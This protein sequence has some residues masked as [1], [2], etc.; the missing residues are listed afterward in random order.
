MTLIFLIIAINC[1]VSLQAIRLQ[2]YRS[3]MCIIIIY[4]SSHILN[5]TH[6]HRRW[7]FNISHATLIGFGAELAHKKNCIVKSFNS[8]RYQSLS[9]S[10]SS[11]FSFFSS[12]S[13]SSS[14][15]S[16]T[17]VGLGI[18][19]FE[20]SCTGGSYT[21]L[22]VYIGFVIFLLALQGTL[23]IVFTIIALTNDD[24]KGTFH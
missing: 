24:P 12:S 2:V 7:I 17:N 13:S 14:S 22:W 19:L 18:A 15:S 9:F 11:S 3:I 20:N 8:Y 5:V 4:V 10:S 6:L 23:F 16:V 1:I 21:I